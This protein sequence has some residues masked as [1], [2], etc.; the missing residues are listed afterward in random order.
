MSAA[1]RSVLPIHPVP[2]SARPG[3]ALDAL[4]DHELAQTTGLS[5][6]QASVARL[7]AWR[8]TNREIADRLGLR[9]STVRRHVEAVFMRVNAGGRR[10]VEAALYQRAFPQPQRLR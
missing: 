3:A 6:R 1:C 8:L 5:P 2:A 9:P 7:L 10:E 4:S